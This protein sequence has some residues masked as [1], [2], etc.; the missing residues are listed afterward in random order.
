MAENTQLKEKDMSEQ[1]NDKLIAVQDALP[2]NFNRQ[3]FIQ[4]SLAVLNTNPG[5]AKYNKSQLL[6]GLIRGAYLGLDFMSNECY[7]VP[8]GNSVN[9]QLSY[10][11]SIKFVKK[12]SIRPI[13]DIYAKAVREGDTFHASIKDGRP[14]LDF[15][16]LPFSNKEIVGVFAVVIYQDGG[17]EYETMTKEEVEKVRNNYSKASNSGAWKTSWEQM[18]LKS[19]LRRLTKR[20]QVD[21]ESVEAHD[22]WEEGGDFEIKKPTTSEIV[23]DPF[24]NPIDVE[25]TEIDFNGDLPEFLQDEVDKNE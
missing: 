1:L 25:A 17:M 23:A 20:I 21:F 16:P 24:E 22:A 2:K 9:F 3:R 7:L 12:Y 5:L 14:T 15:E 11:G 13:Q 10:T 19:V 6:L 4:N 18:A 8:Y